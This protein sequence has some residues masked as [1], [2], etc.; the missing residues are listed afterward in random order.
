MTLATVE[1]TALATLK[2]PGVATA[3]DL[4]GKLFSSGQGLCF[5][6]VKDTLMIYTFVTFQPI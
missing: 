1:A 6:L 2:T 4:A 3:S 5:L